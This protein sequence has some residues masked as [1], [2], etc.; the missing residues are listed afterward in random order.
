MEEPLATIIIPVY[1]VEAYLSACVDSV[2]AQTWRR[3]QIILVDDGSPDRCGEICEEY[4]SLDS[5]VQVIHTENRG[6]GMARNTGLE[7]AAGKYLFF[8]DGDDLI[9]KELVEEA[10]SRMERNDYDACAWGLLKRTPETGRFKKRAPKGVFDLED[11]EEKAHFLCRIFLTHRIGWEVVSLV[12]RRELVEQLCLRFSSEPKSFAEDLD[13]TFRYLTHCHSLYYFARPL[14][15]Y[16]IRISSAMHTFPEEE[17][18]EKLL[19]IL[20]MQKE[21]MLLDESLP[22][23]YIFA[24]V[25]LL[26]FTE[27]MRGAQSPHINME[28]VRQHLMKA[29]DR[30]YL[31]D[32]IPAALSDQRGILRICGLHLGSL[33]YAYYQYLDGQPPKSFHLYVKAWALFL[34]IK[35]WKR[36]LPCHREG[37]DAYL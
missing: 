22:P 20:R 32:Q 8:V 37:K 5:R 33:V 11:A 12:F 7:A 1:G 35:G 21:D 18:T 9:Y 14:Y 31:L 16:R 25:V 26:S 36:K 6:A 23:F 2:L 13:F 15:E 10:V 27:H 3:I 17:R 29:P 30:D 24:G 28:Q 4:A 34:Q 19:H